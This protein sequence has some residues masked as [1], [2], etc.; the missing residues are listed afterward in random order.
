MEESVLDCD[1][2]IHDLLQIPLE[3]GLHEQLVKKYQILPI[4]ILFEDDKT[5]MNERVELGG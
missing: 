2:D 3:I 1:H 5:V 4:V